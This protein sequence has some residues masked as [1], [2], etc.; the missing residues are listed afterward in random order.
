MKFEIVAKGV[1][2]VLV[3]AILGFS[4]GCASLQNAGATDPATKVAVISASVGIAAQMGSSSVIRKHPQYREY[5]VAVGSLL[6]GFCNSG[7]F[8][9]EAI[10]VALSKLTKGNSE[11]QM[12]VMS[13]LAIYQTW[14]AR[15]VSQ[16][17]DK[18]DYVKPVLNALASGVIA[19]AGGTAPRASSASPD[20]AA[21]PL[22][23]K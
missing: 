13:A 6:Q 3:G 21:H 20:L 23:G 10:Q 19:G 4:T 7:N 17:L 8:D 1:S 9:P 22:Q 11:A 5:F 12:G 18:N 15:A 14:Y 16:G 2:I